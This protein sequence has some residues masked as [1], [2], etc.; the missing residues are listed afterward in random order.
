MHHHYE[1]IYVKMGDIRARYGVSHMWVERRLK[2][3]KTFPRPALVVGKRRFWLVTDLVKW[4][5]SRGL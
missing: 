1:G 2:D 3:D 5:R 4:E